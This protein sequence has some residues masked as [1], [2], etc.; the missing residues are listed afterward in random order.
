[1]EP[2]TE[3]PKVETPAA[4]PTE[5]P[6][7]TTPN[8]NTP[9]EENEKPTPRLLDELE[10]ESNSF[11]R[12]KAAPDPARA[13]FP[14]PPAQLP[15]LVLL[16]PDKIPAGMEVKKKVVTIQFPGTTNHVLNTLN[17]YTSD[18]RESFATA[19]M[20]GWKAIFYAN[21]TRY[22]STL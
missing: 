11:T 6:E 9:P 3:T 20:P 21:E 8:S 7:E 15:K 4:A 13:A 10:P 19:S 14:F 5:T 1:M 2:I 16:E 12:K 22:V 17:C 18:L